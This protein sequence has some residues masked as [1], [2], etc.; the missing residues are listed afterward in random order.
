MTKI[1]EIPDN[2]AM[3]DYVSERLIH[4]AMDDALIKLKKGNRI[5]R[6]IQIGFHQETAENMTLYTSAGNP[7]LHY[8]NIPIASLE[9]IQSC[10]KS[11]L[12]N[13]EL[14]NRLCFI[15]VEDTAY[16]FDAL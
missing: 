15:T 10:M 1:I 7:R 16:L 14:W 6:L 12:K 2:C 8:E 9:K 4:K 13:P 3:A 11:W 5:W